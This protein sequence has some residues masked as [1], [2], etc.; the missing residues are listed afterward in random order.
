M[1]ATPATGG[2]DAREITPPP[3]LSGDCDL[4]EAV[5]TDPTPIDATTWAHDS[6]IS[7]LAEQD[8]RQMVRRLTRTEKRKFP[9]GWSLP[10][11]LWL[12]LLDPR[13]LTRPSR[14]FGGIGAGS[15]PKMEGWIF[16]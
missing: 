14:D 16:C 10:S 1:Q 7:D 4:L 3:F 2:F 11:E 15:R 8:I 13:R 12:I 5:R 6:A 9:P